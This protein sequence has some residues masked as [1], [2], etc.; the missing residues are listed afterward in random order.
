MGAGRRLGRGTDASQAASRCGGETR[1]RAISILFSSWTSFI[2]DTY[3]VLTW[4]SRIKSGPGVH[5]SSD[6]PHTRTWRNRRQGHAKEGQSQVAE[7]VTSRLS[8]LCRQLF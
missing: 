8:A 4:N 6:E 3:I 5:A 7:Q 1:G 2:C